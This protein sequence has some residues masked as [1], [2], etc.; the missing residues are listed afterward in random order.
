M[1]ITPHDTRLSPPPSG[2]LSHAQ[3]ALA[4]ADA[5]GNLARRFA[6]VL[7]AG[8]I[9]LLQGNLGAGKSHFARTLIRSLFG[10][11]GERL[12]VPSPTFT[13][14]QTYDAPGAEIWHADLYRLSD[15]QE[16]WEL[17]LDDAFE[18]AICL[19]EWPDRIFPDW[20]ENAVCLRL[21]TPGPAPETRMA[22][23]FAPA[24]SAFAARLS[25]V[26]GTA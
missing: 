1:L 5:T 10:A 3:T 2:W 15:P 17:G 19:I 11:D 26:F 9:V 21:E 20:P 6:G 18:T 25:P 23:L 4:D 16:L 14:V 24:R 8:D 13:L 7:S 22:E 12:E